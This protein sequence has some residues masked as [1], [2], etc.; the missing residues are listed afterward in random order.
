[1]KQSSNSA[2]MQNTNLIRR[3]DLTAYSVSKIKMM[4]A[5]FPGEE[6]FISYGEE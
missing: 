4:K 3:C 6:L 1:M 2:I 5:V